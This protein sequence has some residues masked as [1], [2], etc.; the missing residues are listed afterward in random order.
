MIINVLT[1]EILFDNI[2]IMQ[3]IAFNHLKY[4]VYRIVVKFGQIY[5][6]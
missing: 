5:V 2:Q 1:E 4:V 6:L 3:N